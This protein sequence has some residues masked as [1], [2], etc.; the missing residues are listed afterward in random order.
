[1]KEK[2]LLDIEVYPN[3][4]LLG[5]K[6]YYTGDT[7]SIE[8]SPWIDQRKD[9]ID[10]LNSFTGFVIGFNTIYYDN[11]VLSYIKKEWNQLKDLDA[12]LFCYYIKSFSDL[13]IDSDNNYDQIKQYKYT[14]DKQW[15]D[16][17]LFLYWSKGLRLQKKISLKGLGIQMGYPVV[18]ELPYEP[19]TILSEKQCEDI[20]VYNLVHDLGILK[21]LAEKKKE[22]I[23]LRGYIQKTY[24]IKSWSMDAPKIASE[25][26]LSGYC[27]QTGKD[28]KEVRNSRYIKPN[29]RI[30]DFLPVINFKT[31]FFQNLYE[32][33]SNSRNTFDKQFVFN[34]VGEEN[35]LISIGVGGIHSILENKVYKSNSTHTIITS[36]IASLYPTNIIGYKFIRQELY[37]VLDDYAL[38]KADRI[39]AK[40][41][42][43]KEKDTFLKLILNSASGLMDSEYSWLYSPEQI[44]AL[45]I[46]G[47]IQLLRTL[48]ELTLK[49]LRV[50]S[51]N[52][53]GLECKVPIEKI[54]EYYTIMEKLE[55]EFNFKWEHDIYKSIY[56]Q[57]INSYLAITESNKPKKKG[58]F[59]TEPILGDSVNFLIIP[60]CLELYLTKSI[61][62]NQVLDDPEKYGLHIYDF[63]ASFKV[64]KDYNIL[65]NNNKQQRLNRFYVSKNAP[66][67]YKVKK[68]KGKPDNMLKGWGVQIF[69]NFE[70]KPFKDY[71]IDK[72]YYLDTIHK[73][74]HG[75]E[76][77]QVNLF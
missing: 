20:K 65:W 47:Q 18:M 59:V 43:D 19:N 39:I 22:D 46:T 38:V 58:L 8:I 72:R 69:N 68:T 1:M 50:L 45:R 36:D 75:L 53:D 14:F 44:N 77:Q 15:T 60:K 74:I 70:Q 16:I 5:L 62:P 61:T 23:K 73:V 21:L 17:D 25:Y 55:N 57:H 2:K 48:E 49:E 34:T 10:W 27:K 11:M 32:E 9:L 41:N 33:I 54:P 29:F 30:G 4:F 12:K 6:D 31:T 35:I 24:K 3:Y 64:G 66:Y 51:M 28:K 42:K 40:K 67:L 52:T 71:K 76:N 7:L 37:L 63:C 56:Y 13:I 26:L